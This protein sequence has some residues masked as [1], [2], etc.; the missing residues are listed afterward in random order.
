MPVNL[1]TWE[2]EKSR[3]MVG[4]QPQQIVSKAPSLKVTKAKVERCGSS[5][6]ACF[7]NSKI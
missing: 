6:R 1:S 3:I 5:S 4:G 7:A 2:A